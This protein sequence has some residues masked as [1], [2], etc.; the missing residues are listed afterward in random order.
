ML[1][2]PREEQHFLLHGRGMPARRGEGGG[3]LLGNGSRLDDGIQD[4]DEASRLPQESERLVD[5]R[6]RADVFPSEKVRVSEKGDTATV[7][8]RVLERRSLQRRSRLHLE[9]GSQILSLGFQ[10]ERRHV[11]QRGD[12]LCTTKGETYL[13]ALHRERVL[14]SL[15]KGPPDWG[16]RLPK[17]R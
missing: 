9:S 6:E 8:R 12:V 7:P 4:E 11:Q 14:R 13:Q 10:D 1:L 15:R 5:C 2:V 17:R 16:R 3:R